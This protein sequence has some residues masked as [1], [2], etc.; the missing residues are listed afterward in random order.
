MPNM[1]SRDVAHLNALTVNEACKL[2][3]F[4]RTTFYRLV[5]SR[6]ITARKVGRRTI[7]LLDEL[8]QALKSLPLVG[9]TA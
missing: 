8:E 6:K 1:E 3:G 7:V 2:S 4:G 9:R 5:K